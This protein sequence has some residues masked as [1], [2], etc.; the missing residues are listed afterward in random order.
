MK[1]SAALTVSQHLLMIADRLKTIVMMRSE[2]IGPEKSTGAF[3]HVLR[4][5]RVVLAAWGMEYT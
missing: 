4:G 5:S 2:V 3:D 1:T